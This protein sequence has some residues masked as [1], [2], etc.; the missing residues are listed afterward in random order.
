MRLSSSLQD[1]STSTKTELGTG[2]FDLEFNKSYIH[3]K[4]LRVLQR[5]GAAASS[6][7]KEKSLPTTPSTWKKWIRASLIGL[8]GLLLLLFLIYISSRYYNGSLSHK[9]SEYLVIL[10]CGSTGTRVFVYEWSIVQSLDRRS[11]P[12]VLR[13]LPEGPEK[14]STTRN[15]RAY[16]RMETEPGF[17]KLVRNESGLKAAIKP[18]LQW[19]EKQI[20]KHA[21]KHTSLF[22]Y[23]TAGVRRLPDSDSD[24]LLETA[25]SILKNSSFLCERNWVKIIT[26]MEEAYYGW[27]ALNYHMGMLGSSLAKETYGA[28]DLGGSSLQVTFETGNH[29]YDATSIDL[30]IGVVDHHLSAYSLSGYGL[31]DAFDKSVAHLLRLQGTASLSNGKLEL[32]HP[33][34][35]TGYREEYVC[36]QCGVLNQNG[37]PLTGGTGK[38]KPGMPIE[39]IGVPQW[40]D[41]STL[42]KATVNLSEW[43][44]RSSGI[45]CELRPCALTENLPLPHGQFYAMSGFF[46]VYRFFNLTSDATLDDVLQVGHEFCEK[47]WDVAKNSVVPQPFIEQYCFRAPYIVSLLRDGL[48]ITHDQLLIGSGSITWTLGVA[49]LEAE[50]AFRRKSEF[51]GYSILHASTNPAVLLVLLLISVLLLFAPYHMLSGARPKFHKIIHPSL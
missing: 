38:G 39:L 7:S 33:C 2:D 9:A 21:H 30:S 19:A 32:K 6:F 50:Q 31:N 35:Q 15:G 24:W 14:K 45:D 8:V 26:G 4:S 46:V 28:L 40:E 5:E 12:F 16:Q 47:T 13:S 49:L 44:N 10:D 48:H 51:C 20:P 29:I 36:S 27:I 34:L 1:F 17:G 23:A 22:L 43:L 18:L 42:A 3:N 41:C 37:S 25:W 11:L